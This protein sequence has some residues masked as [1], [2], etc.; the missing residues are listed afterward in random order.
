M[1][2]ELPALING[3]AGTEVQAFC[4]PLPSAVS[5]CCMLRLDLVTAQIPAACVCQPMSPT[6][7]AIG[8]ILPQPHM[9][10]RWI[11][12]PFLVAAPGMAV[13]TWRDELS[14]TRSACGLT[15]SIPS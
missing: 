11:G 12:C 1:T 5:L 15:T 9:S 14:L 2:P 7:R 3:R 6:A 13:E 10:L 8:L 4:S